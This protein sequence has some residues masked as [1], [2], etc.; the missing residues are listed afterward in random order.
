MRGVGLPVFY[1]WC[2]GLAGR[3]RVLSVIIPVIPGSADL[4]P[5]WRDTKTRFG[6]LREFIDKRL[7]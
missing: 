1:L 2:A 7:I 3:R 4:I 5:D 6:L